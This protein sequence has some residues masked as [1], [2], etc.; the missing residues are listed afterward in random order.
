MS[1]INRIGKWSLVAG[2]AMAMA[3]APTASHAAKGLLKMHEGDWTGNL[4]S[5]KLIQIILEDEM[6]YKIKR[7]FLP[8][9]AQVYEAIIA[10]EIDFSCE[11]W[12]SYSPIKEKYLKEYGGDGQVA[13]MGRMT[14]FTL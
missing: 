1:F 10:G 6:D 9:G 5:C 12:P 4:V 14:R 7:V 3:V 13:M 8:T 11:G 2:F